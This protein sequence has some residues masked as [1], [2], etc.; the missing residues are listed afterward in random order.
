MVVYM[1]DY[2]LPHDKG[3]TEDIGVA[4]APIHFEPMDMKMHYVRRDDEFLLYRFVNFGGY[5][6]VMTR[7][8]VPKCSDPMEYVTR[9]YGKPLDNG[10]LIAIRFSPK[11]TP[12]EHYVV[13]A[14]I[15]DITLRNKP[16]WLKASSAGASVKD[17]GFGNTLYKCNPRVLLESLIPIV[18]PKPLAVLTRQFREL[19]LWSVSRDL[20]PEN[21]EVKDVFSLGSTRSARELTAVAHRRFLTPWRVPMDIPYDSWF[22]T[23][24]LPIAAME[25]GHLVAAIS[26]VSWPLP[27]AN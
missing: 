9:H 17:K 14:L 8:D 6:F 5:P 25:D 20:I 7:A 23:I 18:A 19:A 10:R 2:I 3:T 16:D 12:H 26:A 21:I 27:L 1:M 24:A 13:F 4:A 15:M 22:R 11:E